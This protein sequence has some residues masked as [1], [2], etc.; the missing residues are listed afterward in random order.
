MTSKIKIP[1]MS[2]SLFT[3][4]EHFRLI[5][6]VQGWRLCPSALFKPFFFLIHYQDVPPSC[7]LLT[8]LPYLH[9]LLCVLT[10]YKGFFTCP[11][12]LHLWH[13]GSMFFPQKSTHPS[14]MTHLF[15]TLPGVS[16]QEI[17]V[18]LLTISEIQSL[19]V[20]ARTV[21]RVVLGWSF[22]NLVWIWYYH[23]SATKN[24]YCCYRRLCLS[25]W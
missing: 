18:E 15:R 16:S 11:S 13:I 14:L 24:N 20:W 2:K 4:N 5:K 21:S 25:V 3:R 19:G 9:T 6:G 8:F 10:L 12:L 23:S 22:W 17:I 7:S 1:L